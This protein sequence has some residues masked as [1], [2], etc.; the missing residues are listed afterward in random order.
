LDF[1][2]RQSELINTI[3]ELT[4]EMFKQVKSR[5]NFVN[6]KLTIKCDFLIY[7]NQKPR[8]FTL[9]SRGYARLHL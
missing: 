6:E 2:K 1:G 8:L 7:T 5:E 4:H 3:A 9:L